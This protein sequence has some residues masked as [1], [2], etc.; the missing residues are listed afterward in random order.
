MMEYYRIF[1]DVW[2]VFKKFINQTEISVDEYAQECGKVLVR[3]DEKE[4]F[5]KD[6]FCILLKEFERKEKKGKH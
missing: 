6:F 5:L 1:V 2:R 4:D 3:Y